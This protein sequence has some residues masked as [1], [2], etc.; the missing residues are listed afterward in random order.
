M[1]RDSTRRFS[2][3]VENY[4]R[5]RP[6]YP[7]EIVQL[8]ER[9]CQLNVGDKIADIGSGTGILA[10]LFLEAGHSVVGIEPNPEMRQAGAASLAGFEQFRN[11]PG[12]AESTGLPERSTDL[13]TAGQAFH[14]FN[15]A[16]T[17][18]EFRRILR[19]PRWVALIW[20]ERVVPNEGFL[21]GYEQLL[22]R[23]ATDYAQ[24]DHR[25]ID[26]RRITEF[27]EHDEWT[28][29]VFDNSQQFDL[30]GV[31]GR[32]LSS[33]YAPQS[34]SDSFGLMLRELETLFRIHSIDG[35]IE[36]AYKTKV[37]IGKL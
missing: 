2:S 32:L 35:R 23:Y 28:M 3:R 30:P 34:G 20:N 24:V 27:F 4:Q 22:V 14:W 31:R 33:S 18:F 9:E 12:R 11:L 5:Y 8:L 26:G 25:L 6:T 19:L 1:D 7:A 15:P 37:Y 16:L 21:Y 17:R 13:V 10:R 36:F 29:A